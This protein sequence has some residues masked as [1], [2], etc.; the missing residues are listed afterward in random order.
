MICDLIGL[1]EVFVV[2]NGIGREEDW[3]DGGVWE[4]RLFVE[5]FKEEGLDLFVGLFGMIYGLMFVSENGVV[6][7]FWKW[8]ED[9]DEEVLIV[10]V[11][12]CE[13][14]LMFGMKVVFWLDFVWLV[15][16]I[17]DV[18]G[19]LWCFGE[20]VCIVWVFGGVGWGEVVRGGGNGLLG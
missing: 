15:G 5:M 4:C 2:F 14:M 13:I 18:W 1:W 10:V 6:G 8:R 12:G 7:L 19:L 16:G 3:N 11:G 9:I 17:D 20:M